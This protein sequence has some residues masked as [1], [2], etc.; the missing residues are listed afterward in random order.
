[1][2]RINLNKDINCIDRFCK[3]LE[4]GIISTIAYIPKDIKISEISLS[5]LAQLNETSLKLNK[6]VIMLKK[7]VDTAKKD[8]NDVASNL[9]EIDDISERMFTR[10]KLNLYNFRV[11]KLD[12][13]ILEACAY[14]NYINDIDFIHNRDEEDI[15][16]SYTF[17]D[18]EN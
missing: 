3:T 2:E 5:V 10:L 6:L 13:L 4:L 11:A 14:I 1:M 12:I 18:R 8:L 15:T 7:T 17:H 9:D 16:L